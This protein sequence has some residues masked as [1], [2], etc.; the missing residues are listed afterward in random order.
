MR[1]SKR[2][3]RITWINIGITEV[4]NRREVEKNKVIEIDAETNP[5]R[6]VADGLRIWWANKPEYKNRQSNQKIYNN[7]LMISLQLWVLIFSSTSI[8][9]ISLFNYC[10][11]YLLIY[12]MKTKK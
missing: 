6:D 5:I 12:L 3:K 9:L 1:K 11:L 8:I 10:T 2:I 4:E 7:M